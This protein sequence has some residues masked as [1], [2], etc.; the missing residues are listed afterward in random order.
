MTQMFLDMKKPECSSSLCC[1]CTSLPPPHCRRSLAEHYA[2]ASTLL[3]LC[4]E[5]FNCS[6]LDCSLN[7][8]LSGDDALMM[9]CDCEAKRAQ[10]MYALITHFW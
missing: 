2:Q 10:L 9:V 7:C 8:V 6:G 1:S 5:T 3:G 4:S